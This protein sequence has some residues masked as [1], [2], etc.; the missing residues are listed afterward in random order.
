MSTYITRQGE[1]WDKIA[2][3]QCGSLAKMGALMMANTQYIGVYVFPGGVEL[4]LPESADVDEAASGEEMP[5]WK[6]VVV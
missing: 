4:T 6:R 1:M 3:E 2:L 5:P